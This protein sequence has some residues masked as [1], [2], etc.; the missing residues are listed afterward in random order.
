MLIAIHD[1]QKNQAKRQVAHQKLDGQLHDFRCLRCE[2]VES[3]GLF[4]LAQQ[5]V[6]VIVERLLN[7][8]ETVEL[9]L[10]LKPMSMKAMRPTELLIV[11][12]IELNLVLLK[13]RQL[14]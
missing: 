3:I 2:F 12:P 8:I 9:K 14:P 4:D 6:L 1:E 13:M 7:V 11:K 5:L 10:K